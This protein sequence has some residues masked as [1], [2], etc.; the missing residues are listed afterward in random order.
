MK[1]TSVIYGGKVVNLSYLWW[2]GSKH[3]R[4]KK[5][6]YLKD[7]IKKLESKSKNKNSRDMCKSTNKFKKSYQPRTNLVRDTI[8]LWISIKF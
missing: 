5:R 2:E 4:N 6:E 1:I 3:F 8:Y 7:K